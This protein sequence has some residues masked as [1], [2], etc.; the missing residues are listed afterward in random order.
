[1]G[2]LLTVWSAGQPMAGEASRSRAASTGKPAVAKPANV[3]GSVSPP[4][5]TGDEL[6]RMRGVGKQFGGTWACRGVDLTVVAGEVHAVLGENGAGKSTLMKLLHGVYTI[7]EGSIEVAGKALTFASPRDAEAA[8][9]AMIPQELD[10]FPDLSVCEN[11][12]VGR[13]RPRTRFGAFDWAAMRDEARAV[14]TKLGLDIDVRA[15]V[16]S[17]S[18]ASAQMVEIARALIRDARIVLMDEPTAALS[19]NEADRLFAI[20]RDLC[21]RGVGVVYITHRLEEVFEHAT[22]V[23]VMRD[24][25]RVHTGPIGGLDTHAL[26]QLMVGRPLK[27]FFHRTTRSPGDIALKVEGLTRRGAFENVSFELRKGEI[28][29]L[30][31]L[32]GAGRSEL[33]QALFGIAPADGGRV[34]V[35]GRPVTIDTA[36]TALKQGIAYLP[37]ERRSQGLH[38]NFASPWNVAFGNLGAI[39]RLGWV[40]RSQEAAIADKYQALFSIRGDMSSPVGGLSGG[41]QQKVLLSKLLFQ[42][43]EIILLDEPTRGVDVG[44]RAEIYRIIDELANAGK[45]ILMISSEL[46]EVLSMADRI[47]VM[48]RGQLSGPFDGPDFSPQQIGFATA[49]VSMTPDAGAGSGSAP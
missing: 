48:Y 11:L 46:N 29:G 9:V 19:Q 15:P 13:S 30:A 8:G 28:V 25:A 27:K 7:D 47:L 33:A 38:L 18:T 12:F 20:V 35:N 49:G 44:A 5:D 21:A 22:R 39:T 42:N 45:A 37:E 6:C 32:I 34:T 10:L 24:G 3:A 17:L 1:M 41:N 43:P 31:G 14:F 2:Q 4:A 16:R 23:T 40:R 36:A 26:V